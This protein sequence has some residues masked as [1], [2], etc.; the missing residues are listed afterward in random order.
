MNLKQGR[1]DSA[2]RAKENGTS[3]AS[4]TAQDMQETYT[5]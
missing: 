3:K 4:A 2:S 5:S 1:G